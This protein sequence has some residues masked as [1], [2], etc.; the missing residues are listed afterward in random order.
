MTRKEENSGRLD[1]PQNEQF[2]GITLSS[3]L[4]PATLDDLLNYKLARLQAL[5]S[6][7]VVKLCEGRFGVTRREWRF[8]AVLAE[9]GPMSPT[10]LA[11]EAH[12]ELARVSRVL[13]AL[14]EKGLADRQAIAADRR[15]A[16][17]SL[18]PEGRA[19]YA[20]IFPLVAEIN[21]GVVGC[22]SR[23]EAR[24]LEDFLERLTAKAGSTLHPAA[25]PYKADRRRLRPAAN[26]R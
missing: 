2:L 21:A 8:I 3:L 22:L 24:Q 18:T 10:R 19:L 15:R 12:L 16:T 9:K 25:L 5:S 17:V 11:A 7:P 6:V 26:R 13:T 23:E 4:A 14:A 20:Q 1:A